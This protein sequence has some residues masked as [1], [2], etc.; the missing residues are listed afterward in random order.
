MTVKYYYY[1]YFVFF[2][3]METVHFCVYDDVI[4]V[5]MDRN[6]NYSVRV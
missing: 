5:C 2:L 4:C 6:S 1:Y 3:Y